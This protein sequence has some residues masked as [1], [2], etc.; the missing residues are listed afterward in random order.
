MLIRRLVTFYP[1]EKFLLF[2]VTIVDLFQQFH[3]VVYLIFALFV[4][5]RGCQ[6]SL[7]LVNSLLKWIDCSFSQADLIFAFLNR[8]IDLFVLDWL[9]GCFLSIICVRFIAWIIRFLSE[10]GG[11][12]IL[13]VLLLV[14]KSW[15]L[16]FLL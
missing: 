8:M 3:C 13:N 12:M 1:S 6:L 5:L 9:V 14:I 4:C 15:L 2:L 10:A 11:V 7:I 16:P